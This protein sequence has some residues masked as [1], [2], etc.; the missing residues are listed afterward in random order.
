MDLLNIPYTF[1][2]WKTSYTICKTLG[3]VQTPILTNLRPHT[4]H[5]A[6]CPANHLQSITTPGSHTGNIHKLGRLVAHEWW[7]VTDKDA[8]SKERYVFLFK[9]RLLVCKVRRISDDRSVFVLRDIVRLP[10]AEVTDKPNGAAGIERGS[11]ETYLPATGAVLV[12]SAHQDETRVKWL[13]EIGNYGSDPL[14]L[15]EHAIDDLRIDPSHTKADSDADAFRL[16]PRIDAHE[17]DLVKPSEVAQD[18]LP[19]AVKSH[20]SEVVAEA[21]LKPSHSASVQ[22]ETTT[23]ISQQQIGVTSATVTKSSASQESTAVSLTATV[24]Q[25]KTAETKTQQSVTQSSSKLTT[26]AVSVKSA[27]EVKVEVENQINLSKSLAAKSN[28]EPPTVQPIA[29]LETVSAIAKQTSITTIDSTLATVAPVAA[30]VKTDADQPKTTTAPVA[31]DV[32][33]E[34]SRIPK[35]VAKP[36][37]VEKEPSPPKVATEPKAP[38]T[39]SASRASSAVAPE[40]I[41]KSPIQGIYLWAFDMRDTIDLF[42]EPTFLHTHT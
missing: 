17:P 10:D 20:T 35:P 21:T 3:G 29:E 41:P 6:Y 32:K 33:K 11:I 14:A 28:T 8:K 1:T 30:A 39:S 31:V 4:A 42:A 40:T 23:A 12:F 15:H 19:T 38:N 5:T 7:T 9:S 2:H 26:A 37:V 24:E 25:S 18:Y 16:P 36:T 22:K 34:V 13:R 27:A